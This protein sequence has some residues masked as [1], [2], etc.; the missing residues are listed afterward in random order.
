[1]GKSLRGE[2]QMIKC[3][4][5]RKVG[6][7][8]RVWIMGESLWGESQMMEC[9]DQRKVGDTVRF[10]MRAALSL[11]NSS[12]HVASP[13]LAHYIIFGKSEMDTW[14]SYLSHNREWNEECVKR[15]DCVH[16]PR[17]RGPLVIH[18]LVDR[19]EIR[20]HCMS[21]RSSSSN[22]I[23]SSFDPESIIRNRRRNLAHAECIGDAIVVPPVLANQFEL[24]TGLLNLVTAISFHGFAND[25]PHSHIRRFTKITQTVK[26]NQ[27]PHDI[28]KLILFPFSLKGTARTWPEKEPPNSITTWN[29]VSFSEAWE[30]FKDLLNKCPHHGFSPFHQIDTL[31]NGLNQSDQDSLNSAAGRNLLTRNTQEALTII[32][33]KSK[34]RTSRNKP[35]VSSTSDSSSKNDAI[36][37][38]T[39]QVAALVSSM[40][41]PIHSIQEGCETCGGPHPYYKCQA[42]GGYTQDV[43]ATTGTY[44]AG[45]NSYQ[46]QGNRNLL[47]YCSDNFIGP[48]G[49]LPSNTEPNLREQVNSITTRSGLT[50]AEP[51]IPPPVP[52]TPGVEVEKEPE[53]LI[54]EVHITS[55]GSI[56]HVP[57][58]GIQRVSPPKPKED[59][60][61][62]L[63]QSKIPY[64]LR[65]NKTKLLDKNDV[66]VSKFLKILKQL[67]FD[68]SLMDALTQI[69]K[70]HKV[71]KDL[72]KDKEKLE[73]LA[74]TL[75]NAKCSAILLN[76]VLEKLGDPEKFLIP[77][78]LQDLEVCN[79]LADSGS[80]INLMPL[81]IYEK[82]G[83]GP[84]KPTRMTLELAN[85]SVT[86]P[87]GI[88]EDVIV[89]VNKFNFLA[90]F[91]IVDFEA[92]SRVP[93]ILGIPFLRTAKALVDLYEE[94]LTLRIR[95]EELVFRAANFSKNSPSRECHSI[96]SINII[97][98]S[99]EEI[100][101]QNKQSSD[102]TT[103]HSDL[104]LP[105]YEVFCFDINHQEEKSS[106][107]TTS[108]S[109]HSLLD[110]KAFCF[111]VD[112]IEEKS[113]GSTTSYSNLSLLEYE[114]FHFD[115]SID[116]LPH[117]D[118]SDSQH[119]E[120][121]NELAHIISPP[122]YD[123]FYF[124]LE[125]DPGE[126]TRLLKENISN[127]STKDLTFNELNDFPLLLSDCDSTF[128]KEFS[129]I[130]LLVSFPSGN[131]DKIFDLGIFII[132]GVQ[133][134][135]FHILP[136]D[137][138]STISFV[139]D[140]LFLID[141]SEIKTFLSFPSGNE[142]RV[143]DPVILL[144]DGIFSFLRKS[145]HLLIDNFMIDNCSI[146]S[147]I[148]LKNVSSISFHP[149]DKEIQGDSS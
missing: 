63:H 113:S 71:L 68:I 132:K 10:G 48:P 67:H 56:A 25:D 4:D 27:V 106:G 148:S 77:S 40:N 121:T 52:P 135:I 44:N 92:D 83:V 120:F 133:S 123:H 70:Y 134:Q 145:P 116:P 125:A 140:S 108:H 43:Y 51:S 136:L 45:G 53:T 65:L 2:S 90:D 129:E 84:L 119:E 146:L 138:F 55:P 49:A 29:D 130:D 144:N 21:T 57:P 79:S 6:D 75:K 101:N 33:N 58:L 109:D 9:K 19:A 61:P 95:N 87:T 30:R 47:S 139:S 94:K 122:E 91:I 96:H 5:Q 111:D 112:H 141:P 93:I 115:L 22:L 41:K 85:R 73:E 62:N 69:P 7:N 39:K 78:V 107:S 105:D 8:A 42:A 149:K 88:D 74:N 59:P 15:I 117:A 137:D 31:Y 147:E 13:T 23:L 38:L 12:Q 89:K 131:K 99:Y 32:E 103:S 104:S 36:T 46:P 118:R 128:S 82:H 14:L 81:S 24:K 11:I 18:S 3:K 28:I 66:Q 76:K 80:S 142:D 98:S 1:M 16:K 126:L 17:S 20:W 127:T 64:P 114:S 26:L 124:D 35:Q 100:S 110:Y 54:D 102:S 143:F 97:D 37:A 72:L 34:V 60:K 86:Y 50:T